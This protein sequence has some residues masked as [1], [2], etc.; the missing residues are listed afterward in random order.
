MAMTSDSSCRMEGQTS[1]CRGLVWLY[2]P[3][4]SSS[5]SR[6]SWP[7]MYRAPDTLLLPSVICRSFAACKAVSQLCRYSLAAT[8]Q[9]CMSMQWCLC[10]PMSEVHCRAMEE[11]LLAFDLKVANLCLHQCGITAKSACP[12]LSFYYRHDPAD[13]VNSFTRPGKVKQA[14]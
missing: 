3:Y 2:M 10:A 14:Q 13:C 8:A 4:A 11:P 7:A 9:Q 12:N 6:C 5:S 1:V